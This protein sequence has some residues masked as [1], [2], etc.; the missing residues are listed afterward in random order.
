MGPSPCF[1]ESLAYLE[2]RILTCHLARSFSFRFPADMGEGI[3]YCFESGYRN[4]FTASIPRIMV[5]L[6]LIVGL[7]AEGAQV[8]LQENTSDVVY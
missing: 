2:M 5:K 4:Y 1:D 8:V 3:T 7:P 6:S